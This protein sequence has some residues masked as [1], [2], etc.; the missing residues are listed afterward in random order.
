MPY[1]RIIFVVADEEDKARQKAAQ[2]A[3]AEGPI[4]HRHRGQICTDNT[5]YIYCSRDSLPFPTKG[6]NIDVAYLTQAVVDYISTQPIS[7]SAS[8]LI[9]GMIHHVRNKGTRLSYIQDEDQGWF[10]LR[11]TSGQA[12]RIPLSCG[13][14][15]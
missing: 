4:V 6:A 15:G 8:C 14:G 5:S 1:R 11:G 12:F 9:A 10:Q 13:T 2:L 7:D 3:Q